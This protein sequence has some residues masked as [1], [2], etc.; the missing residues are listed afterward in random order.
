MFRRHKKYPDIGY[1]SI[2]IDLPG[3]GPCRLVIV[4]NLREDEPE[5]STVEVKYLVASDPHMHG[6]RVVRIY[7]MRWKIELVRAG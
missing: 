5:G 4:Q 7:K 2:V 1:A 3:H 6:S